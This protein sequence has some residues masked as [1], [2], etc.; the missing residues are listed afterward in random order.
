V[1]MEADRPDRPGRS[2]H[3]MRKTNRHMSALQE[4]LQVESEV[5][6]MACILVQHCV[7]D[8]DK[9]KAVFDGQKALRQAAGSK[10]GTVFRNADDANQITV[11]LEWDDLDSA[12]AFTGSDDLREAMQRAGVTGRPDIRFLD[13][14]D[15]PA[16]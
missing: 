6:T 5:I 1:L 4:A 15:R 9:W 10:G 3:S 2:E 16:A 7:E 14:A 8:Y 13:E 11:L 12:R